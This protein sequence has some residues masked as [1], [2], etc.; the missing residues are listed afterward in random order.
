M[1]Y[2]V[3]TVWD[4]SVMRLMIRVLISRSKVLTVPMSSALSGIMLKRVPLVIFPTEMTAG[5]TVKLDSL[6]IM[7]CNPSIIFAE[8]RIGSTPDQGWDPWV[9]FPLILI[10][11]NFV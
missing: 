5:S 11:N 4:I 3:I 9:C 1:L 7:V 8:I 6:L 10:R 2:E